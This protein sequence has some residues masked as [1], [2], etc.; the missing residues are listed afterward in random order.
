[1]THVGHLINRYIP[2][3]AENP[4]T[5]FGFS[6]PADPGSAMPRSSDPNRCSAAEIEPLLPLAATTRGRRK[7]PALPSPPQERIRPAVPPREPEVVTLEVKTAHSAGHL[8]TTRWQRAALR[9]LPFFGG[10]RAMVHGTKPPMIAH[11]RA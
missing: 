11:S 10:M 8:E 9:L 7:G 2:F 5:R 1:M 3:S 4:C 6:K